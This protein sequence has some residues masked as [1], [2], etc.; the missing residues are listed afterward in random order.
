MTNNNPVIGWS[1]AF[2]SSYPTVPFTNDR[3]EALIHRIRK[4]KYNFNYF[5]HCNIDYCAPFYADNTICVL[6]KS[7]FDSV[8]DEAWEYYPRGQR[9]MPE[10]VL[11]EEPINSVIYEKVKWKPQGG[12]NNG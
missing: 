10:D 11:K 6:T 4:R 7:E 12:D 5:D 3:R 1:S 8:M 9:L 2:F